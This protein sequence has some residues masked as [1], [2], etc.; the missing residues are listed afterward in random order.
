MMDIALG[1]MACA[2]FA[3]LAAVSVTAALRSAR[4]E[5][6]IGQVFS[7]WIEDRSGK[8]GR[9]RLRGARPALAVVIV[10]ALAGAAR[11]WL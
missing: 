8:P 2:V 7:P 6:I 4:A 9:P 5:N 1:L 11:I 3:A 10:L